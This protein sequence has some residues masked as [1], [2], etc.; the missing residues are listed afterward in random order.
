MIVTVNQCNRV[1]NMQIV[2]CHLR[3]RLPLLPLLQLAKSI[4]GNGRGTCWLRSRHLCHERDQTR[5]I[6][7]SHKQAQHPDSPPCFRIQDMRRAVRRTTYRTM[8]T[9]IS[10]CLRRIARKTHAHQ[11]TH[12]V[13]ISVH[14]QRW[15]SCALRRRRRLKRS[16][17]P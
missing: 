9:M 11:H 12:P 3:R 4:L 10:R 14:G 1:S 7:G 2:L 6:Y 15:A 5:P 16:R 17:W 13:A 8:V